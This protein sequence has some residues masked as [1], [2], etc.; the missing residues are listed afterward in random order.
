M[1][2][3][4]ILILHTCVNITEKSLKKPVKANNSCLYK[5][6]GTAV[7]TMAVLQEAK[8]GSDSII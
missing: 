2:H 3:L 4:D 8:F 5:R 7:S 1:P 6:Y